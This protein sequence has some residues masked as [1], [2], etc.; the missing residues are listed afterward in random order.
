MNIT[1]R[2][3]R[4]VPYD[5][6]K[7][8]AAL[9]KAFAATGHT[10]YDTA[11]ATLTSSIENSVFEY[12][13]P[14][15]DYINDCAQWALVKADFLDVAKA[16]IS[17]RH[18]RDLARRYNTTDESILAL[19]ARQND[20]LAVENS[21]KNPIM[22][23]TMRDYV[24]G[25]VSKD[26]AK[27]VM[28]PKHLSE[29]HEAGAIHTHDLDFLINP[30]FN[31][32]LLDISTSLENGFVVNKVFID[33]PK[34]FRV[35]CSV[36]CQLIRNVGA[37]QYGG[38]TIDVRHLGKYLR[39][40]HAT[41]RDTH[42]RRHPNASKEE[43]DSWVAEDLNKE[44]VAGVK[45][46]QYEVSASASVNG[47]SP[48][49][50]LFLNLAPDDPYRDEV[51][52]II[53]A[54]LKERIRGVKNEKRVRNTPT[55]PKLVYRLDEHNLPKQGQYKEL[56]KTAVLC[57]A[58]RMQPDYLS[59]K[60]M[61]ENYEGNV[62][63]PMGC[64]AFLS[65]WKD[66]NGEYKFEGRFNQGAVSIN[67]PQ[68]GLVADGD[69]DKFWS[70]FDERLS[71]CF[72][73][74]MF[75]HNQLKNISSNSSPVHWQGGVISSLP[76]NSSIEDMLYGGYS[77]ISLGYIGI[78]ELTKLMKGCSH[79]SPEGT[80][81]AMKVMAHLKNTVDRW[82][83][84]TNIGFGLYGTPAESLS[85]R[86]AKIDKAT[87][88]SVTDVTDKDYYTNS[89]HVDVRENIDVFSKFAFE[90]PFQKISSSG[91]ISYA[92]IPNMK[93]NLDALETMVEYIYDNVQYAQFNTRADFCH[94]CSFDG[95]IVINDKNQWECPQCGNKDKEKMNVVRRTCGYLGENFWNEGKTK[96]MSMR[97]FHV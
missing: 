17:Y 54:I 42:T 83:A 16:F 70:L 25:E 10:D 29:A 66:E 2:D 47:Q 9:S 22:A 69:E 60:I 23:S 74:L 5:A 89:F 45:T 33:S 96:E 28:M 18:N 91:C 34:S 85:H 82:K 21:N 1:K 80:D 61:K 56:T 15:V 36:T 72:E 35:A 37:N 52:L 93:N 77:T 92:E 27:R 78:Y 48:F 87:F 11:V 50:T 58:T 19:I 3:S 75:R 95:E 32:C 57:T 62:F 14:T 44:L 31:C 59:A 24:A 76:K 67:L 65:P 20:D 30:M 6:T 84:E 43:I 64:R 68:I 73:A 94:E 90:A 38:Q 4:I 41:I 79:T 13:A 7:I 26:M 71:L 46:I 81:F 51:C 53:D 8:S 49:V 88:G 86:F 63:P 12:E 55:F 39:L 97:V 40:S